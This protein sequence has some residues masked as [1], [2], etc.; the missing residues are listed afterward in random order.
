LEVGIWSFARF[1]AIPP[2]AL[3]FPSCRPAAALA[4]A[5]LFS[6]LN[7][8]AQSL[9]PP[10]PL[11]LETLAAFRPTGTN[12]QLAGGLAG[13]PRHESALTAM[14]GSG[15]L[16]DNPS[17]AMHDPL[18]T[19]WMHGDV[20]LDLDVLLTTGARARIYLQG[21]YAVQLRDS[22]GVR[23]PGVADSGG[24]ALRG[25]EGHAPRANASHAP[26]LWQHLHIEFKAPRF[27]ASGKKTT[28]ARF[29]RVAL[30][31]FAVQEDIDV[32]GPASGAV[33]ADEKQLGPLVIQGDV[34][35]IAVRAIALKQFDAGAEMKIQN[36]GYQLYAGEFPKIG[37]YESVAPKSVGT[38]ARFSQAAV[39]KSGEF[40]L[41]FTGSL[42]A[43]RDG[44]YAF[45][46]TGNDPVRF[47]IDDQLVVV[48][49]ERG[50]QPG[51]INLTA[52]VHPFRLD[53]LRNGL[54]GRPALEV[55]VEGPGLAPQRLT[56]N[57][58]RPAPLALKQI[59]VEPTD[60]V[61]LQR[62]FVP[63]E[64]KKR[65]YAASI[66]TPAGV[67][68]AYDFETGALLRVWRG[69][70][71]DTTEM[72][73]GRGENQIGKPAGPA[74]T[75]NAKPTVALIE[76]PQTSDWPDQPDAMQAS[77][78]YSLEKDGQPVFWSTL[79]GL[80]IRDRIAPTADGHGLT[81]T[82][83]F[84]GWLA[85]WQAWVL[86]AEADIITPQPDGR[87]WIVGD[88]GYYLD[89]PANSTHVAIVRTRAGHQQL[90]VHLM[91]T[92]LTEPLVYTLVW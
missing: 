63:Y 41:V 13:D 2:M 51:K 68:Y 89:W 76:F 70:F 8:A 73:D 74:L 53:Y 90:V 87:G 83:N 52:G 75:L 42:V 39:E 19:A 43:P 21:R 77:R 49:L 3:S 80:S 58:S 86:I 24:I 64:P 44:E 10:T 72:W 1:L 88:R 27:D 66:G 81:R 23:E 12:W 6:S 28:S 61:L 20:E 40:A 16:V 29:T 84:S 11:P 45:T 14:P 54:R 36:L 30:N 38:P 18:V 69:G 57:D 22:W 26:G 5:A 71:L 37:D 25:D 9:L 4:A 85:D 46:I 47:L 62:C 82:L 35:A 67:H 78:G 92:T 55:S 7:L 17:N 59:L 56:A 79:A 91:K 34:G 32:S 60:R 48:P 31:G 50:G 15:V 65:L 33:A